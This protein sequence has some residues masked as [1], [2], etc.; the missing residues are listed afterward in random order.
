[1]TINREEAYKKVMREI[2][3]SSKWNSIEFS[4]KLQIIKSL[5]SIF[6][7]MDEEHLSVMTAEFVLNEI[8]MRG[9]RSKS[10]N[11]LSQN[12]VKLDKSLDRE[13]LFA[14]KEKL[15]EVIFGNAAQKKR[16]ID[17]VTGVDL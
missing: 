10:I 13:V 3:Q 1:M 14:D 2:M 17:T 11:N 15:K 9:D 4:Q 6:K 5:S 7:K 16:D 8:S 12:L